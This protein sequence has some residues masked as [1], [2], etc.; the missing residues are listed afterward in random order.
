MVETHEY[1]IFESFIINIHVQEQQV[2]DNLLFI[3]YLLTVNFHSYF[4]A[5]EIL[6]KNVALHTS[7]SYLNVLSVLF[8]KYSAH[9]KF[10]S[11]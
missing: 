9:V 4:Y 5:Y 8:M 6:D 11:N 10:I 2:T 3:S 1:N 7:S